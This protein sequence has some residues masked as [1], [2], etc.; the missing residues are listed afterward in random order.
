MTNNALAG[1]V[2]TVASTLPVQLRNA[3][4]GLHRRIRHGIEAAF[5]A[6]LSKLLGGI[7][8]D[9][10]A[11]QPGGA[12]AG[13]QRRADAAAIAARRAAAGEP[14]ARGRAERGDRG[15]KCARA[16]SGR[17]KARILQEQTLDAEQKKYA[18]GASVIY[19]VILTQRD[20]ATARQSELAAEAAYAKSKVELER[21]TGQTLNHNGISL[22]EAFQGWYRVPP[23]RCRPRISQANNHRP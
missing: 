18:A 19:N 23:V 1:Q 14:G 8:P 21:V 7:Q 11:A 17:H 2:N 20:L 10:S 13:H 16:I 15:A 4:P 12:G 9:H 22:R 3:Q 6:R 5:R